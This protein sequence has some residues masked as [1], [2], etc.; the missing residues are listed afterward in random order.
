[1]SSESDSRTVRERVPSAL[2]DAADQNNAVMLLLGVLT[3]ASIALLGN[4]AVAVPVLGSV[5]GLLVGGV[6]L[7]VA[8]V[9]Y[10]RTGSGCG[11][12]GDCGDS[13]SYDP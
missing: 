12:D 7:A 3:G 8:A 9:V 13:C 2:R 4:D 6:G 1:M 10:R 5:P 11:C